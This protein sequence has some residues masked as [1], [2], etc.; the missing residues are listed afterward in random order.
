MRPIIDVTNIGGKKPYT[1]KHK[2]E[3]T[4]QR[5]HSRFESFHDRL[6]ADNLTLTAIGVGLA[7]ING[8]M[9]FAVGMYFFTAEISIEELGI[10]IF[11]CAALDAYLIYLWNDIKTSLF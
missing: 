2:H 8:L 7:L 5:K 3:E 11:M 9:A 1:S 4:Y 10:V 6:T